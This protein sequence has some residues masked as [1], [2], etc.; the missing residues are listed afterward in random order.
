M[1]SSVFLDEAI[2]RVENCECASCQPLLDATAEDW[3]AV[4][5]VAVLSRNSGL[6]TASELING[7]DP[8][9]MIDN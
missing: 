7:F 5:D 4:L 9:C 2:S 1:V 3:D 8:H 6:V